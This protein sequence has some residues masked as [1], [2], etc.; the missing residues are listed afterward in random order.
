MK[1]QTRVGKV[2]IPRI[3]IPPSP[4]GLAIR[5]LTLAVLSITFYREVREIKRQKDEDSK[6]AR[7][8]DRV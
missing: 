7:R 3:P 8:E 5:L 4:L 6:R 1:D 2:Q